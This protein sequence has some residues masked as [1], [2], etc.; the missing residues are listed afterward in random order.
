MATTKSDGRQRAA[1][2]LQGVAIAKSQFTHDPVCYE[3]ANEGG[4][5]AV[6]DGRP[7]VVEVFVQH[8][9]E[10]VDHTPDEARKLAYDLLAAADMAELSGVRGGD[11]DGA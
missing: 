11:H 1:N 3:T 2:V 7:G 4:S 5:V 9:E 10:P 6:P 8:W